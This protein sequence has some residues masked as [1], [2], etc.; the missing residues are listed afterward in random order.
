VLAVDDGI[1]SPELVAGRY[2]VA[3]RLA[4]GGMGSVYRVFDEVEK[5]EV[6]LKRMSGE[7]DARRRTRM[8]E[9][10]YHTLAGLKHPGIIEVY[11][12]G[13]DER[14]PYYTMELLDGQDLREVTPLPYEQA[15]SCLRDVASSLALLHARGLLHRDLSARNVR[16]T[17]SGRAKLLDFGTLA[18][19]GRNETLVGTAPL[20]PPESFYR[21]DLDQ[22]A[23]LYALG[24]L[25][26][27]T[28]TGRH[29]REVRALA[30]LPAA[31]AKP[32][33][34]PSEALPANAGL[35][36]IPAELD[37]LI[38]ALLSRNPLARPTTAAEVITRLSTIG[39]LTPDEEPL[40]LLSYL[41]GGRPVG[42]V[43]QRSKLRKHLSEALAVHGS[44][45]EVEAEA[46]MGV[47]RMLT[48]LAI[49]ARLLGATAVVVN[50][51]AHRGAYAVVH[52]LVR[53]L[54]TAQPEHARE[55]AR[56][57]SAELAR[58]LDGSQPRV[59]QRLDVNP[60]QTGSPDPREARMRMQAALLEWF[61]QVS[62]QVPLMLAVH[63]LEHADDNSTALL[64]ALA[65]GVHERHMLIVL[66]SNSD[67]P[68]PASAAYFALRQSALQLRIRGLERDD[69]RAL[70]ENTFGAVQNSERLAV[71]LHQL[72]AGKPEA[73]VDLMQHL[74]EQGVI[75]FNEGL[76]LL[77]Q[78]LSAH[79]LPVDLGTVLDARIGRL[80]TAAQRLVS[81]IAVHRGPMPLDRCLAIAEQEHLAQ[82]QRALAELES[83][84]VIVIADDSLHFN[85]VALREAVL[86]RLSRHEREQLHAELGAL[87]SRQGSSDA[88]AVL[89]AGWHLLHGG[90]Q[91]R[92]AELL[93]QAGVALSFDA[94]G[95]P[96]AI[97]ALRAALEAFR[98][99]HRHP[100]E[101][102]R[103]LAALATGGFFTDRAVIEQYGDEAA[104]LVHR[105]LG[106]SLAD[107]LAKWC[108]PWLATR[109]G[110]GVGLARIALRAGP[111]KA[112]AAL[113]ELVQL[114]IPLALAL[115]GH[116]TI[117]LDGAR[118]RRYARL[119]EP[120]R[121]LGPEHAA[122][123]IHRLAHVLS[124][125]PEDNIVQTL[126]GL[127]S[128]RARLEDPRPIQDMPEQSRRFVL[129]T[130]LYA[131]GALEAFRE[132]SE[133]LAIADR[134]ESMGIKLFE[135]FAN[136]LR[137]NYH[138]LRGE[139]GACE[140]YR[141]RVEVF[142]V[143]AGSGWQ[144]EIWAPTSEISFYHR[145]GD[146]VGIRRVMG[147][148]ERMVKAIPSLH[149]QT[150]IAI[151]T[152]SHMRGNHA[153]SKEIIAGVLDAVAPRAFIGWTATVGAQ[154]H[155]LIELGEPAQARELGLRTLEPL[156]PE[157][158]SLT[159]MITPII[160][161]LALADAALGD[162]ESAA[163][164]I[165]GYLAEI[166]RDVGATT[167]GILHE[168]GARI[169]Q[170]AGDEAAAKQ[171]L[172][173]VG[174]CFQASDNPALIARW[175]GLRRE[176]EREPA[177]SMSARAGMLDGAPEVNRVRAALLAC[178]G[179]RERYDRALELLLERTG[180]PS[181]YLFSC[182]DMEL[183]LVSPR[184]ADAAPDEVVE[185]VRRAAE[186]RV[187]T[188][189][190]TDVV[191]TSADSEL[192]TL[193]QHRGRYCTY[194]LDFGQA[195]SSKAI[196][197]AAVA[198]GDK[199][200][201]AP[202]ATFLTA[203]VEGLTN[204]ASP[205]VVHFHLSRPSLSSVASDWKGERGHS[206]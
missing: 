95:L 25:G 165:D 54:A 142:A 35:P 60:A 122:T 182:D 77:P 119:L 124:T 43:R 173:E 88:G 37:E 145:T 196:A 193:V 172:E 79:E 40:S 69:V 195:G 121:A 132:S 63:N 169:A 136:Q 16:V 29:A 161:N 82:P 15:C 117:T 41:R 39:A 47:G 141:R 87:L 144:A 128:V 26:Y 44:L 125:L 109:I 126:H 167:R 123:L 106:L 93:A 198:V 108:G 184:D 153:G 114:F 36:A 62:A 28:L 51:S 204:A 73:C 90:E 120:L 112:V 189:D 104:T 206:D 202:T 181:G 11:D 10:E 1:P 8:F 149:Q 12:Y 105:A 146:I 59:V 17:S 22:R 45:I 170:R 24:A 178:E 14:G 98:I 23:D 19:F 177:R 116:G 70:V 20:V 21:A 164:R 180:G 32:L 155:N 185:L 186:E 107:R 31:Y 64:A 42:R 129:G 174:R 151:A 152:Y 162:F 75:R 66:G 7:G 130:T 81:S 34:P 3:A 86:R 134:L 76:W 4:T 113:Q 56:A 140:L 94:D 97:P 67:E 96:A 84:G 48:D 143:Q 201:S 127:R 101:L 100:H 203:L 71:W 168:A 171:H 118:A 80:S 46:G 13:I 2:R 159:V 55:A 74:V 52:E 111:R 30:E 50:A 68:A 85:H 102:A 72:T 175:E 5:R 160:V 33:T 83:R 190:K 138:G 139:V 187:R 131:L 57:H 9:R 137:T 135:L 6:A 115:T 38:L 157:E 61:E 147:Q 99:Q 92:G 91:R 154:M 191:E 199:R 53:G 183:Q 148:L 103:V 158:R 78:E 65:N 192:A 166:D 89:D 133:V 18:D 156:G 197:V 205:S 110:L 200:L 188:E 194:L 176:I 179:P 58:F 27:W 49:E 150:Q 163:A